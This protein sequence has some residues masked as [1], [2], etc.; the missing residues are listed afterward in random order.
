MAGG[1]M[2]LLRFLVVISQQP[3][4]VAEIGL[5]VAILCGCGRSVGLPLLFWHER[6]HPQLL[7]GLAATLLVFEVV[8]VD[9]LLTGAASFPGSSGLLR[10]LAS[11]VGIWV[12]LV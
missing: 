7:A 2:T 12:L 9:Y 10:F 11:G 8:F 6:H 1:L 3:L 4:L 5:I